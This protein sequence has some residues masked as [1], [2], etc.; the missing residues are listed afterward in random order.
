MMSL[1]WKGFTVKEWGTPAEGG[2]ESSRIMTLSLSQN[3]YLKKDWR[4]TH[5]GGRAIPLVGA[6]FLVL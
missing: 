3:P 2:S 5:I 6:L 4:G 1:G